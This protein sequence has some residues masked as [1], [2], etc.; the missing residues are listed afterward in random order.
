MLSRFNRL[1][2]VLCLI[3]ISLYI[4][5][6]NRDTVTFSI[7]GA[8]AITANL[9][10]LLISAFSAGLLV[11]SMIALLFGFKAW[12]R[13]RKLL[14]LDRQRQNFIDGMV[15]ARNLS[16]SADWEKARDLW[17]SLSRRDPSDIIGRLEYAGALE[18]DGEYSEALKEVESVRADHPE[19]IEALFR[20]AELQKFLGNGTAAI[21][22][23]AL[24]LSRQPCLKAATDARAL[25]EKLGR[26][27]DAIEYHEQCVTLGESHD[28]AVQHGAVL[29]LKLLLQ[30]GAQKDSE[31][32]RKEL[33]GFLK[34]HP[35][36]VEAHQALARIAQKNGQN[37]EAAQALINAAK[38]GA[39]VEAWNEAAALWLSDGRPEKALAAARAAAQGTSGVK[40]VE[41]DL[42]RAQL[43]VGLSQA[44]EAEK[45]LETINEYIKS[46]NLTVP[47]E[48]E[49]RLL[50]LSTLCAYRL[51]KSSLVVEKLSDLSGI[52]HQVNSN[53]A[54][55][56]RKSRPEP[57]PVFSTP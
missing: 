53:G 19:N 14:S 17:H 23:L 15:R 37:E 1:L 16:A 2:V 45:V 20:A 4:V 12:M 38:S 33:I 9:G 22:N 11:A 26:I 56:T 3:A 39:G 34:R 50:G 43:H 7:G 32:V 48:I 6:L 27:S 10:V 25:S 8:W 52:E 21:D 35:N 47:V 31:T 54:G 18:K 28:S 57:S 13:E 36:V 55:G 51:G 42:F 29:Q 44:E 5:M 40:K 24:I 41:A 46:Q 30:E 49:S